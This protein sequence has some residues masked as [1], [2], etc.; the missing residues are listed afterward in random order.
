VTLGLVL[1]S[2]LC[3]S[4]VD[5]F[6]EIPGA[7][8]EVPVDGPMSSAG[9]G[10]RAKAVRSTAAPREVLA[11]ISKSFRKAGLFIPPPEEQFELQT[12][13][14]LTG[15]DAAAKRS[16]T[17]IFKPDGKG[18]VVILGTADLKAREKPE[19]AL[20]RFPG[21]VD[22]VESAGEGG[23]VL[24]YRVSASADDVRRFY[25]DVLKAAGWAWREEPRRWELGRRAMTVETQS[26]SWACCSSS[27]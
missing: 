27:W 11:A 1:A 9:V 20:P 2:A 10:V 12:A 26:S 23:R 7:V 8:E 18:T 21:G 17:A 15:Y 3:A 13:P 25:G 4:P 5:P 14:Q 22:A 6:G 19:G 16:Y 24:S